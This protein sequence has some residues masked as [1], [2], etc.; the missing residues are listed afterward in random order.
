MRIV[1][2]SRYLRIVISKT[3]GDTAM[4]NTQVRHT[5]NKI[6]LALWAFGS[7]IALV[8]TYLA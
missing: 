3:L 8:Y 2:L 7:F 6:E 1:T 4:E 5:R